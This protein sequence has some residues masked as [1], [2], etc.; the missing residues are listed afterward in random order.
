[1]STNDKTWKPTNTKLPLSEMDI[2]AW[3]MGR[4][5]IALA[6]TSP[7]VIFQHLGHRYRI[8]VRLSIEEDA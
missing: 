4:Q 5:M 3:A 7:F 8:D 1:M 6:P 2:Q